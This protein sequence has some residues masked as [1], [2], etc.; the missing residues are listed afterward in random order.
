MT[1]RQDNFNSIIMEHLQQSVT[2][3]GSL[4]NKNYGGNSN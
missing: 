4:S 2:S 3:N 1:E